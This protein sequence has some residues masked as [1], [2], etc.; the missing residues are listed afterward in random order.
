MSQRIIWS[1]GGILIGTDDADYVDFPYAQTKIRFSPEY[2][3]FQTIGRQDRY[4]FKGWRVYVSAVLHNII[5]G[6]PEKW[7]ALIGYLNS[8]MTNGNINWICPRYDSGIAIENRAAYLMALQ[9]DI[10]PQDIG[11]GAAQSIELSWKS[12]YLI[13]QLPSYANNY[14]LSTWADEDGDFYQDELG[15]QYQLQS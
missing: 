9:T 6:D 7:Q 4:V 5:E 13:D 2:N 8:G 11:Q 14:E 3:K 10:D 15:N 1:Y 12:I